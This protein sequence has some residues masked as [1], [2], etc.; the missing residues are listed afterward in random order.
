MAPILIRTSMMTIGAGPPPPRAVRA[1]AARNRRGGRP[2]DQS[3]VVP[4]RLRPQG[5]DVGVRNFRSGDDA[6]GRWAPDALSI[7]HAVADEPSVRRPGAES[8]VAAR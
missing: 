7:P 3:P 4:T 5:R 8:A 6:R 2:A 1:D